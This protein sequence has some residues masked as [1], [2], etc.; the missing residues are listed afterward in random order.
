MMR[1]TKVLSMYT[2]WLGFL[3]GLWA[4][5]SVS[6]TPP[7]DIVLA[8]GRVIDPET[9]LDAVRNIGI[10]DGRIAAISPSALQGQ[11]VVATRWSS[12]VEA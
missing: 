7:Y 10:K 6:I 3:P 9:K 2:I 4:Q 12:A 1:I 11:V 5:M 8:N